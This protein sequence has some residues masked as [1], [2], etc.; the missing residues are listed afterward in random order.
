METQTKRPHLTYEE[1]VA[2]YP[3]LTSAM[4]WVAILSEPEAGCALRNHR[5]GFDFACEAV[6]HYGGCLKVIRN[7]IRS[8]HVAKR[9]RGGTLRRNRV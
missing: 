1:C 9:S 2:R 6:D 3:R 7:A 4:Q 8:R 5:N